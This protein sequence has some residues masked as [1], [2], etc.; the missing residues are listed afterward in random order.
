[1]QDSNNDDDTKKN[2]IKSKIFVF[3][4]FLFKFLH[5]VDSCGL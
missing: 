2:A 1:L 4:W 3:I 5:F